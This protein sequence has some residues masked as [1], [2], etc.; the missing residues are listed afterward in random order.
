MLRLRTSDGVAF[1]ELGR[2]FGPR[3]GAVAA[4][5]CR[6]AAAELP[7]HWVRG[8]GGAPAVTGLAAGVPGEVAASVAESA[9]ATL[10]LAEPE[11]FLFSNDAIATVFARLDER[12]ARARTERSE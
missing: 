9:D 3:L 5:A 4:A 8:G 11:G 2:R 10:A 12:L 7:P 1:G 6:D